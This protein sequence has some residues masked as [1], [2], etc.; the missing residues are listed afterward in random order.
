MKSPHLTLALPL[1]IAATGCSDSDKYPTAEDK[2]KFAH[3]TVA[4]TR[5][6]LLHGKGRE[7]GRECVAD[8]HLGEVKCFEPD[9]DGGSRHV[10]WVKRDNID[11]QYTIRD[12]RDGKYVVEL[13]PSVPMIESKEP[14]VAELIMP[15]DADSLRRDIDRLLK[16]K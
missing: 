2:L 12:F 11:K 7:D 8:L 14:R 16:G 4:E 10:L 9:E 15:S 3:D 5:A 13:T 1:L 6:S